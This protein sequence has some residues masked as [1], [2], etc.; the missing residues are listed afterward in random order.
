[1]EVAFR[2]KLV[3]GTANFVRNEDVEVAFRT[4]LVVGGRA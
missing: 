1:V 4:K 3:R 2:T